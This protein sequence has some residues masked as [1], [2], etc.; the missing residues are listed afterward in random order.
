ILINATSARLKTYRL[1]GGQVCRAAGT[2]PLRSASSTETAHLAS[3]ARQNRAF[4]AQKASVDPVAAWLC[5]RRWWPFF[6]EICR[7]VA[8]LFRRRCLVCPMCPKVSLFHLPL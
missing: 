5:E 8:E 7:I 4:A 1:T 6:H 2:I 3:R